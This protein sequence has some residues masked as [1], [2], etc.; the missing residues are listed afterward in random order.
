[1]DR[2][3]RNSLAPPVTR[4]PATGARWRASGRAFVL[5]VVALIVLVIVAGCGPEQTSVVAPKGP[6]A[7]RIAGLWW[8]MLVLAVAIFAALMVLLLAALFRPRHGDEESL[9]P[10]GETPVTINAPPGDYEYY[11]SVPGHRAAGMVGTL[12]VE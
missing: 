5:G 12:P 1:M 6:Q 4:T 10:G 7:E 2:C 8:V 11:C 3:T 9:P